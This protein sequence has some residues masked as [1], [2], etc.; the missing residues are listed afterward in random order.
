M[1]KWFTKTDY[2]LTSRTPE[3][4]SKSHSKQPNFFQSFC[5]E[6]FSST[7]SYRVYF[8]NIC[9]SYLKLYVLASWT[10]RV[11]KSVN[12]PVSDMKISDKKVCQYLKIPPIL[13]MKINIF[14]DKNF[15]AIIDF[16]CKDSATKMRKDII[17]SE[18]FAIA[19]MFGIRSQTWKNS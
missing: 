6:I 19:D 13:N 7:G 3:G 18:F 4:F 9:I 10:I 2:E 1:K 14:A 15:F 16:E 8:P 11:P 5:R 12:F 17:R